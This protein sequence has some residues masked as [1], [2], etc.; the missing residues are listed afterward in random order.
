MRRAFPLIVWLIA[1]GVSI[2]HA[3]TKF[4]IESDVAHEFALYQNIIARGYWT[5]IPDDRISYL[6]NSCLSVTLLP[7]SIQ[8]ILGTD[9]NWTF[10]LYSSIFL[11]FLPLVVYFIARKFITPF[12]SFLVA[13]FTIFQYI[14]LRAPYYTRTLMADLFFALA[15]LIVLWK[16]KRVWLK[17]VLLSVVIVG[18]ALSHYTV[19]FISVAV[20]VGATVILLI[21]NRKLPKEL[22]FAS[23]V[24]IVSIGIWDGIINPTPLHE[25]TYLVRAV[26]QSISGSNIV[27]S[28]FSSNITGNALLSADSREGVVQVAFG[29]SFLTMSLIKKIEFIWNWAIIGVMCAGLLIAVIRRKTD[30]RYLAITVVGVAIIGAT[31]IFPVLSNDYGIART[32]YQLMLPLAVFMVIACNWIGTKLKIQP[33]YLMLGLL[34]PYISTIGTRIWA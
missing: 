17:Y 2:T 4:V 6:L 34:I 21:K 8:R 28:N 5:P 14:F 25:A 29:S 20:F 27:S 26:F 13:V 32:Y 22:G 7:A 15:I 30:D 31:V 3:L 16:P 12:N 23:L 10:K 11:P 9:V 19:A 33:T 24:M 1:F 18:I